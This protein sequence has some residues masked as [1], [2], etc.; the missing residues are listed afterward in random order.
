MSYW[1][2]LWS[3]SRQVDYIWIPHPFSIDGVL[4]CCFLILH[5][6][7]TIKENLV[8]MYD[9]IPGASVSLCFLVLMASIITLRFFFPFPIFQMT[10]FL[11][12]QSTHRSIISL[13][14][15][16]SFHCT[17]SIVGLILIYWKAFPFI[18]LF[19]TQVD[20]KERFS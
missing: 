8:G 1:F 6:I 17:K 16:S 4:I 3:Q 13:E 15:I 18:Y 12:L 7:I 9:H 20:S 5:S 11:A 14:A 2:H 10:E 19:C